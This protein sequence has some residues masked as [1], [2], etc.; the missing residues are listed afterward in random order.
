MNKINKLIIYEA[1][2]CC[3]GGVCG[4]A[5]N[6]N[7]TGLNDRLDNIIKSGVIVERYSITQNIKKFMEDPQI[8]KLIQEQQLTALPIT[9]LNGKVIKV[10][11]YP[12][13]EE[14]QALLSVDVNRGELSAEQTKTAEHQ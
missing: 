12:T 9:V 3:S 5:P 2:M 1:A 11:S 8:V 7:M 13:T 14:L 4:S 6:Q 10:G